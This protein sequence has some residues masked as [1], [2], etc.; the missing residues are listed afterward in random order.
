LTPA[1]AS[2]QAAIQQVWTSDELEAH[3]L[4]PNSWVAFYSGEG[5]HGMLTLHVGGTGGGVGRFL[6]AK[7]LPKAE[8]FGSRNKEVKKLVTRWDGHVVELIA[9]VA[10]AAAS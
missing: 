7:D 2:L 6:K 5:K 3:G 1:L 8:K 9:E 4:P 10:R